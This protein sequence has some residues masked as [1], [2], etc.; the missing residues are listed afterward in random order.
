M[1]KPVFAALPEVMKEDD[2]ALY[3]KLRSLHC[4]RNLESHQ[5]AGR[6]VLDRLGL[7]LQCRLCGDVRSLFAKQEVTDEIAK[8]MREAPYVVIDSWSGMLDHVNSA[9]SEI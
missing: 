3:Q 5:C 9:D 4:D 6:L 2:A 8:R 1:V 7:T